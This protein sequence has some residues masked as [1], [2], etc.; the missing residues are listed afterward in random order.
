M[1][2]SGKQFSCDVVIIHVPQSQDMSSLYQTEPLQQR[3]LT[4]NVGSRCAC[5]AVEWSSLWVRR[6]VCETTCLFWCS[7]VCRRMCARTFCPTHCNSTFKYGN[8]EVKAVSHCHNGVV[9]HEFLLP[10][11]GKTVWFAI[12]AMTLQK[13]WMFFDSRNVMILWSGKR[14]N[15]DYLGKVTPKGKCYHFAEGAVGD[16][17]C[18]AQTVNTPW[19][20][21]VRHC[22]NRTSL[23]IVLIGTGD[24]E[25]IFQMC[26]LRAKTQ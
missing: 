4:R 13:R 3:W 25:Q 16:R 17:K 1:T 8:K 26:S 6:W 2:M 24:K 21:L 14:P 15:A 12:S 23:M 7:F 11:D 10:R 19:S 5:D 22:G 9:C 18:I 20:T